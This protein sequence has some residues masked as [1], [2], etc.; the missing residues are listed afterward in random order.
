MCAQGDIHMGTSEKT[1]SASQDKR[2]QQNQPHRHLGLG[3]P[4]SRSVGNVL[5]KPRHLQHFGM[6]ARTEKLRRGPLKDFM[7]RSTA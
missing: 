4:A 2:R 6:A 3:F 1:S 5:F 7:H